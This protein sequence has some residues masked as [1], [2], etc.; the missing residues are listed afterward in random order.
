MRGFIYRLGQSLKDRGE[1]AGHKR[2]WYAG[3]MIRVGLSI[4]EL[5]LNMR[6]AW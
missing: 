6:T 4:R 2:R 5:A 1:C 3:A